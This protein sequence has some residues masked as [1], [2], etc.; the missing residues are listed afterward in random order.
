MDFSERIEFLL[1][2]NNEKR[3]H[4]A[5]ILGLPNQAFTNW[6]KRGNI[7]SAT[8]VL[9]IAE[10]FNVSMEW[11]LTGQ[12]AKNDISQEDKELLENYHQLSTDNQ[13]VIQGTMQLMLQQGKSAAI[14]G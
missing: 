6:K 4:L 8:I 14:V 9:Q 1:K 7:P 11:L 10:H 12:E 5:E 2:E 13:A 3:V